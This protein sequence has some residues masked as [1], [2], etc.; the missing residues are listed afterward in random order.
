[1]RA[2]VKTTKMV[3]VVALRIT[4]AGG[5]KK[6]EQHGVS[7]GGLLNLTITLRAV[8]IVLRPTR[9]P[10]LLDHCRW[11]P[12][13]GDL[14]GRGSGDVHANRAVYGGGGNNG[15]GHSF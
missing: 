2:R 13:S 1:M 15:F 6:N 4:R 3:N 14:C 11:P 9:Q 10:E 8:Q 5:E 12:R 7:P